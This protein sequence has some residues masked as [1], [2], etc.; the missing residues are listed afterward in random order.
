MERSNQVRTTAWWWSTFAGSP[1]RFQSK[2]KGPLIQVSVNEGRLCVWFL[3]IFPL[4]KGARQS[5]LNLQIIRTLRNSGTTHVTVAEIAITTS[6]TTT[7]LNSHA[8]LYTKGQR[9]ARSLDRKITYTQNAWLVM[10]ILPSISLLQD[11]FLTFYFYKWPVFYHSKNHNHEKN[12]SK[13]KNLILCVPV[14]LPV[15]G[16]GCEVTAFQIDHNVAKN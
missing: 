16:H 3:L 11:F 15:D 5:F 4:Y 14:R 7:F 9:T 13:R 10:M 6:D 2:T 8:R 12:S 1:F